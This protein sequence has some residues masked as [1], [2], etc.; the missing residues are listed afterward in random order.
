MSILGPKSSGSDFQGKSLQLN[1]PLPAKFSALAI[2]W[3][4]I[5]ALISIVLFLLHFNRKECLFKFHLVE[6]TAAECSVLFHNMLLCWKRLFN[7]KNW[8]GTFWMAVFTQINISFLKSLP[9]FQPEPKYIYCSILNFLLNF[10]LKFLF[11]LSVN[12]Q[13]NWKSFN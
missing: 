2:F 1:M 6:Q 13:W 3:E 9:N 12:F 4:N 11:R 5:S 10:H 7:L 8:D